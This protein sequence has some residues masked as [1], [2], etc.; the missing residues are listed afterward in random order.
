MTCNINNKLINKYILPIAIIIIF[1]FLGICYIIFSFA[2]NES[3]AVFVSEPGKSNIAILAAGKDNV[4]GLTDV[5]LL[6]NVNLEYGKVNIV[7][8]PRDTFLT[9]PDGTKGKIN[10]ASYAL[11]GLNRLAAVLENA[12]GI[13]IDH[14]V[15]FTLETFSRFIDLIGGVEVNVPCDMNYDDPGQGLSIHLK[16]GNQ[17]LYGKQ[18][19]Q[20]VRYRSGYIQGDIARI[21]AQ[22][23]FIAALANKLKNGLSPYKIPAITGALIG[24]ISTD[25]SLRQC[26][27]L[28]EFALNVDVSNVTLTTFPGEAVRTK[29][30][31][32]A[33]YYVIYKRAACDIIN[34]YFV[35]AA[36]DYDSFDPYEMFS[37]STYPH[38]E[39]IYCSDRYTIVEYTADDI[40]ENGIDID[41]TPK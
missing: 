1:L 29:V 3:E 24:D 12:L 10:S 39:K 31:S 13:E 21:D 23:I 41:L 35:C 19:A 36:S 4:S 17:L 11:G 25:M 7:Q 27:S 32:G 38:F 33:W 16:A 15:T 26:I 8:I 9:R 14:T 37:S 40:L 18:A 5:L 30:T 22:K 28:A 2:G 6:V 34:K 20:F